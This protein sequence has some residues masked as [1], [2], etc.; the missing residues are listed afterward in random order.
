VVKDAD[1]AGRVVKDAEVEDVVEELRP[2][3]WQS[4]NIGVNRGVSYPVNGALFPGAVLVRSV[5]AV[6]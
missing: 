3:L 5:C 4:V 2:T 1:G 6:A